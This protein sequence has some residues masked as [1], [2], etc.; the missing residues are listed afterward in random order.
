MDN[1]PYTNLHDLNL[2]WI[3]KTVAEYK[4]KYAGFD[5]QV[6]AAIQRV[7]AQGDTEAEQLET[8]TQTL[9]GVVETAETLALSNIEAEKSTA[10]EA[11]QAEQNTAIEAVQ[12]TQTTASESITEQTTLAIANYLSMAH[13][14]ES[15][16]S[17]I[18]AELPADD[19]SLL[20]KVLLLSKVVSGNVTQSMTWFYTNYED[21]QVPDQ[22]QILTASEISSY[23]ILG[24][25]GMQISISFRD[26]QQ[27]DKYIKGVNWFTGYDDQASKYTGF[28]SIFFLGQS[29]S[30]RWAV[31]DTC[32][33]FSIVLATI[34]TDFD[35]VVPSVSAF[36]YTP[37]ELRFDEIE[38]GVNKLKSADERASKS[39]N[40]VVTALG[41]DIPL[42]AIRTSKM[43][44]TSNEEINESDTR[45]FYKINN[46]GG[47]S[48]L[49]FKFYGTGTRTHYFNQFSEDGTLLQTESFSHDSATGEYSA[50][51]DDSCDYVII[52]I[53]ITNE[54]W[55]CKTSK[56]N[57]INEIQSDI[58]D[59]EGYISDIPDIESDVTNLNIEINGG[60]KT[61]TPISTDSMYNGSGEQKSPT[62]VNK[63]FQING[64]SEIE[65]IT[66]TFS[67]SV[68]G[69]VVHWFNQFGS[70][71]TLLD[72]SSDNIGAGDDKTLTKT[73]LSNCAYAKVSVWTDNETWTAQSGMIASSV[74][75]KS[76]IKH[77]SKVSAIGD[78]ITSGYISQA[79]GHT[80]N[81]YQKL[82]ADTLEA[83][84]Q[85]LGVG[86]TPVCPNANNDLPAEKKAQS[87][88]Y[89]Y[90]NIAA[91]ADL[92]IIAGGTNDFRYDVPIGEPTDDDSDYEDTFY[93]AC[94]YLL[95]NIIANHITSKIVW[96]TPFH[97]SNDT[98]A[99][100]AG[101]QLED[102]ITA[103]K[104]KC[105]KYGTTC[106]D[107]LACSGINLSSAFAA[108]MIRGG[109][110]P[111]EAG[112][113]LI[114]KNLMPYFAML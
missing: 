14:Y 6:E 36:W 1:W 89:R 92:I 109:V 2:D 50:T 30:V 52:S 91:D 60:V 79:D 95:K 42:F 19:A 82:I 85:K 44:N 105:R 81:T 29:R 96:V 65:S 88:V 35:S 54:P 67:K 63:F 46:V 99:N 45:I 4:D 112:H 71:D 110:H 10:I 8:L 55:N 58:S 87:L 13:I 38:N 41:G 32:Y 15:R 11:V 7:I 83:D 98:T 75:K 26:G 34:D 73:L 94:D 86:S 37:D 84:F 21:G 33:A 3:I 101:H 107:G 51:I 93:G 111:T 62:D 113:L 103:I 43:Y 104:A 57:V 69:H 90:S 61:F 64:L 56:P 48:S 12:A 74:I 31:P 47:L 27:T 114:Y 77:F 100:G 24:A 102:Y 40:P 20:S 25:A 108:E 78:S 17:T 72:Y 106:I 22:T 49:E 53:W 70:D 39:I 16:L 5:E 68:S 23:A 80:D 76:D 28:N 66:F 9:K 18:I 97:Q 59:L